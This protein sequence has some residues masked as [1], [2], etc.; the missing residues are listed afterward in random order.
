MVLNW[1]VLISPTILFMHADDVA[2]MSQKMVVQHM[3]LI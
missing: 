1:L 2:I 3:L